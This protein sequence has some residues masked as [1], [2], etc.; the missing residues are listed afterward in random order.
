MIDGM[1]RSPYTG[2]CVLHAKTKG[3]QILEPA[4]PLVKGTY[5]PFPQVRRVDLQ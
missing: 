3:N 5:V 4:T 2:L 1:I